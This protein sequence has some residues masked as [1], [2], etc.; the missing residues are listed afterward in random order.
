MFL[1]LPVLVYLGL[2]VVALMLAVL[3]AAQLSHPP[4]RSGWLADDVILGVSFTSLSV[5]TQTSKVSTN[6]VSF[7]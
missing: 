6:S 3:P 2:L 1:N 4:S 7:A 5:K